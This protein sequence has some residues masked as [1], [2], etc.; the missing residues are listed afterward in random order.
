MKWKEIESDIVLALRCVKVRR[1]PHR[2]GK[3]YSHCVDKAFHTPKFSHGLAE[4]QSSVAGI[5]PIVLA[6]F[7]VFAPA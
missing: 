7:G 1:Y 4:Y 6:R 2:N 5:A 3:I